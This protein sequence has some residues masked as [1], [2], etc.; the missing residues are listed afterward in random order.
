M[1]H[2]LIILFLGIV[3]CSFTFKNAD[4]KLYFTATQSATTSSILSARKKALMF[5][6]NT[7]ATMVNGK[8][9]NVTKSYIDHN[10]D[11]GKSA[12]EFMTETRMTAN[13]LLQNVE[14]AD[15]NIVQEKKGKYTV[16]ITLKLKKNEVLKALCKRL[17]ENKVTKETFQKEV[18]TDLWNKENK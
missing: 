1:K 7:L 14:I 9:N 16:Y 11:T 18:F 6:K 13:M 3:C 5:A 15:E 2:C 10:T 8:V 4:D 17:N 12:D